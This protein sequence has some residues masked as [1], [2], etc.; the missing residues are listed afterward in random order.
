M[1]MGRCRKMLDGVSVGGSAG[2]RG[3]RAFETS[4]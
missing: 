2:V 3:V 4:R 1:M